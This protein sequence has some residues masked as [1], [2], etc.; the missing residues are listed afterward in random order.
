[1]GSLLGSE[2]RPSNITILHAKNAADSLLHFIPILESFAVSWCHLLDGQRTSLARLINWSLTICIYIEQ[3]FIVS[4]SMVLFSQ[5]AVTLSE[6][7]ELCVSHAVS[8]LSV[9]EQCDTENVAPKD[10]C[11]LH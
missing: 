5:S 7:L 2:K 4:K 10:G 9:T 6:C 1:M 3:V 11:Q 8:C